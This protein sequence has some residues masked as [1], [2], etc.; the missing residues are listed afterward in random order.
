M[1]KQVFLATAAAVALCAA[2][3]AYAGPYVA[4][5]V[6]G[7]SATVENPSGSMPQKLDMSG[8]AGGGEVGYLSD[9][10]G[11][12]IKLGAFASFGT[13]GG[14]SGESKILS[15]P[16]VY[17]G[18]DIYQIDNASGGFLGTARGLVGMSFFGNRLFVAA[19]GGAAYLQATDVQKYTDS[20]GWSYRTDKNGIGYA[21]G[22][23]VLYALGQHWAVGFDYTH[24]SVDLGGNGA[25]GPG[26]HYYGNW[27]VTSDQYSGLLAYSFN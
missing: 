8:I 13:A 3:A 27:R 16:A 9:D 26:Y 19:D 23:R 5:S 2:S 24:I 20:S 21:V 25:D 12:G 17:C 4:L 15:C 14:I 10:V 18:T 6:G 1:T 22:G 11:Y 7:G